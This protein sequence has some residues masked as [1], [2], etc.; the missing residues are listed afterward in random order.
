MERTVREIR[1]QSG[2]TASYVAEK[3]NLKK[4]SYLRRERG[5]VDFSA[6]EIK[7]FSILTGVPVLNIK[8]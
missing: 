4:A 7:L 8:V 2:L 1:I 3:L 6:R 5:E